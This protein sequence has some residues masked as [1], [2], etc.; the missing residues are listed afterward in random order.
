MPGTALDDAD[1]G[2]LITAMGYAV[3][4][5]R[6]GDG[7]SLVVVRTHRLRGAFE[8]DNQ[9]YRPPGELE[10][11]TEAD[12]LSSYTATLLA[13]GVVSRAWVD[14]VQTEAEAEFDA[15][16]AFAESSPDPDPATA[17]EGLFA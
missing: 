5:A 3:C 10:R 8:G 17:Q 7:P 16:L 9:S 11:E 15:A 13:T 12:A 14:Q 4:R 1:V 2:A 6:A